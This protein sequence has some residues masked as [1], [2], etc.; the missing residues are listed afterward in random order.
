MNETINYSKLTVGGRISI[1]EL[2]LLEKWTNWFYFERDGKITKKPTAKVNHPETWLTFADAAQRASIQ[3]MGV[4]IMFAPLLSDLAICGID[5]DAHHVE[6]NPLTKKVLNMFQGTYIER[7]PSG[8]GFHVLFLVQLNKLPAKD[9]YKLTYYQKNSD[10]DIECYISGMTNRFFT[11]TGNQITD[12]DYLADKTDTLLLFLDKYMKRNVNDSQQLDLTAGVECRQE[13]TA[14]AVCDDIQHRLFVASHAKNGELFNSLYNGNIGDYPSMS[15][16]VQ[17]L[18]NMLVFYFGD[19]GA[20]LVR[21]MFMSSGLATGKWAKRND[22]I[23]ATIENAFN[24][25]SERYRPNQ[26]RQQIRNN[27]NSDLTHSGGAVS[28]KKKDK[29]VLECYQQFEN[30]LDSHGYSIRYNQITKDF[31]FSGFNS[32]ESMEHLPE[33][34]PRILHD[35]LKF[36]FKGVSINAVSDYIT[37]YAT[38]HRYNPVLNAIQSVVWDGRDRITEI[39]QMFKIPA[40]TEQG[41]YCRVFIQKW[42]MQCVCGLFNTIDNPFSLDIVLVF[43]GRQGIGKTRFFEKL[44]LKSQYFGEGISLDPRNKDC[45]IQSSGKWISELGELGST[46]RKDMDSVKAFLSKSTD[47][48]RLPYGRANLRHPRMT[49]FVGTV[50]D[51]K[52]LIDETGN[53]R[54]VVIPLADDLMIDYEKQIKPFDALQLWSQVYNMVR[55]REKSSCFRLSTEEKAYLMKHNEKF[56]KPLKGEDDVLDVLTKLQTPQPGYTCTWREM[57]VL[58]FIQE[59]QLFKYDSR[60]VGKVLKKYGYTGVLS[61]DGKRVCRLIRLPYKKFNGSSY[62]IF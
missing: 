53:R 12:C 24:R 61:R 8:K 1:P 2:K 26:P 9:V 55:D 44:A 31:E 40:D 39:F 56:M 60:T 51:D 50:N 62:Q 14:D 25:V 21:D 5:I 35:E 32:A 17:A 58:E 20:G 19:G 23:D 4:G 10:L 29:P 6:T 11:F 27:N 37:I 13:Q 45:I 36:Y 15:E 46:M 42:L 7:S 3:N 59:N 54:F 41:L 43:Q 52:F 30:F 18:M 22:I 57:T 49:S 28:P 38:R 33:T 47:E 16:A 34:A 48:Y